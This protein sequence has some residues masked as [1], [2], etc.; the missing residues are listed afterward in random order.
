MVFNFDFIILYFGVVLLKCK[1]CKSKD[2]KEIDIEDKYYYCNR[3]ELIFI[4][5][6]SLPDDQQELNNYN[7]HENTDQNQ[8]YVDMFEHFIEHFIVEFIE[9]NYQ[10][11]EYGCGPGPVLADLLEKRGFSVKK[12]D[13]FF[14]PNQKYLNNKYDLITSTEVFEHFH[15]PYDEIKKIVELLELNSYLA[16]MTSFHKGIDHFKSWWYKRDNTH[17]SFFNLTT[18]H[19]IEK[20]FNL[21]IVKTDY[22]KHIVFKK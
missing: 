6:I 11:L 19:Y 21:K 5:D 14:Y 12:Y 20:E 4:K 22:E 9:K 3:C 8:G 17:V 7:Q 10:V 2:L 1:L 18:F 16:I 13:P 15:N